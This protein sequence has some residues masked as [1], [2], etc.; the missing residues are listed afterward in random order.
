MQ[1]NKTQ[2]FDGVPSKVWNFTIGGYQVCKKWLKDRRGRTLALDDVRH[3]QKIVVAF[4]R[5]DELM[6][7]I[8]AASRN[9]RWSKQLF[10]A[11]I[12]V[13]SWF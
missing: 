11:A 13:N 8:D 7:E 12:R 9:G 3:D 1:I 6:T 5:T 10:F 4:Q 2:Y